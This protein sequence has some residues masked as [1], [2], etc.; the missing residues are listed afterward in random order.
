MTIKA[1]YVQPA[2]GFDRATLGVTES[3]APKRGE[4]IYE[5]SHQHFG[6]ICLDI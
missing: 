6:K 3:S 2:G 1:I 4:I 5:E